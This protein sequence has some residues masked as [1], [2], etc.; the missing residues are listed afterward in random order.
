MEKGAGITFLN[1]VKLPGIPGPRN[2]ISQSG[3][4]GHCTIEQH[5]GSEGNGE[6]NLVS[7]FHVGVF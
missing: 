6:E 2:K 3:K 4:K 5:V 1:R 7:V